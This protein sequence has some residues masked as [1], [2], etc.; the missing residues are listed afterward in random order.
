MDHRPN[1]QAP[2]SVPVTAKVDEK[3]PQ[4]RQPRGE[5]ADQPGLIALPDMR[6]AERTHAPA[7]PLTLGDEGAD[8][9]DGA[10]EGRGGAGN[11][12]WVAVRGHAM[13]RA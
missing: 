7:R 11:I 12:H 4:D 13:R 8:A 6:R 1:T 10:V 3:R 5:I 9:G 2:Q